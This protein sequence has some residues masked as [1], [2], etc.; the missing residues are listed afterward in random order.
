MKKISESPFKIYKMEEITPD[1]SDKEDEYFQDSKDFDSELDDLDDEYGFDA[2]MKSED[3]ELFDFDNGEIDESDFDDESESEF[4][5]DRMESEDDQPNNDFQG[6]I[7]NV[8][9]AILVYKRQADDSTFEEL[10][11]YNV[12][13]DIKHE[14][15]LRRAILS[16]TDISPQTGHSKDRKQTSKLYSV[17]NVQYLNIFGLP[18]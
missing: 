1:N 8:P 14:M 3:E 16:G 18:N 10:W 4:D 7:R 12:G 13:R 15:K 17:G 9:G 6:N 5:D 11:L 2:E